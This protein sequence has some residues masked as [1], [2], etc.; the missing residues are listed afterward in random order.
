MF[1]FSSL[2]ISQRSANNFQ[3]NIQFKLFGVF[4][5]FIFLR[6][7]KLEGFIFQRKGP[8]SDFV[9]FIFRVT[10]LDIFTGKHSE[11][12]HRGSDTNC[13][14]E[15]YGE[16]TGLWPALLFNTPAGTLSQELKA[17][18]QKCQVMTFSFPFENY[19]TVIWI[20]SVR[21]L[22]SPCFFFPLNCFYFSNRRQ[23]KLHVLHLCAKPI[24]CYYGHQWACESIISRW[25]V[26]HWPF[27]P[28]SLVERNVSS[29]ELSILKH[30]LPVI[31]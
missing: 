7:C 9:V 17:L 6:M 11:P 25:A 22:F 8:V 20:L 15:T 19:P 4:L 27:H 10:R 21:K 29:T 24:F 30:V 12:L 26:F 16:C 1:R 23:A 2:G 3:R 13:P 31:L 28:L 5:G 14:R 18:P